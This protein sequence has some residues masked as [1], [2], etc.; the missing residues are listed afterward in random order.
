[1]EEVK[2]SN[3]C[4][5]NYERAE[6]PMLMIRKKVRKSIRERRRRRGK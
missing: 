4:V 6:V 3:V 1:M 5:I 2:V